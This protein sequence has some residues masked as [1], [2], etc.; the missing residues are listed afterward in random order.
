MIHNSKHIVIFTGGTI[1]KGYFVDKSIKEADT[2][3]AADSGATTAFSFGKKPEL[4]IGDF[5]SLDEKILKKFQ[6]DNSQT[7][8]IQ[9]PK[10][11]DETDTQLAIEKAI[12]QKAT[13]ITVIGGIEGDRVD[14]VL[15]NIFLL[16]AYDMPIYFVNGDIM[17]WIAKGTKTVSIEGNKNDLISLIPLQQDVTGI[18]TLNLQYALTDGT[19]SFGKSHGISNVMTDKKATVTFAKGTL[20]F[21]QTKI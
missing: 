6:D 9:F 8:I 10:E 18:T 13:K 20:L 11:K 21:A 15:A 12:E 5:D 4:V 2:I 17:C 19:L 16:T 7:K 14:H 1:R 3:F